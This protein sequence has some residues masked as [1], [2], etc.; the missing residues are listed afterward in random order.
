MLDPKI[1]RILS[2]VSGSI[3]RGRNNPLSHVPSSF[4]LSFLTQIRSLA[5]PLS[6]SLYSF[7]CHLLFHRLSVVFLS[8][9]SYL[10]PKVHPTLGLCNFSSSPLLTCYHHLVS[11]S[12]PPSIIY[13]HWIQLINV[14]TYTPTRF[15]NI[16]LHHFKWTRRGTLPETSLV[17]CIET[18]TAADHSLIAM[19]L[20]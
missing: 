6:P 16:M 2:S 7:L 14:C 1:A 19:F 17:K 12:I 4:S 3:R 5:I 15:R 9:P 18:V 13:S 10:S 8:L 20:C 11:L